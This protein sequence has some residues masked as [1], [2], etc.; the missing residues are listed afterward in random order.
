MGVSLETVVGLSS[1]QNL[2]PHQEKHLY[3]LVASSVRSMIGLFLFFVCDRVYPVGWLLLIF[4]ILV[5]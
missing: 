2:L 4:E 3:S 5:R 1:H